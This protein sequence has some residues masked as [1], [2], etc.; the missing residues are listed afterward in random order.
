[1]NGIDIKCPNIIELIITEIDTIMI[2]IMEERKKRI[3]MVN[4]IQ[5]M[6]LFIKCFITKN[7]QKIYIYNV[8]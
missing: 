6:Y 4:I 2:F 1:M 8:E 7:I 3:E 5:D